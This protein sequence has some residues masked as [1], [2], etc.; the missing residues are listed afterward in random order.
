MA[1]K[2]VKV[3]DAL[4]RD[5]KMRALSLGMKLRDATVDAFVEWLRAHPLKRAKA[6][7]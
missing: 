5:V 4:H 6:A 2:S 3:P 7:K 1:E